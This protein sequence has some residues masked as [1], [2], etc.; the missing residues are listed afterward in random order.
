MSKW[1]DKPV[2]EGERTT[3][4]PFVAEDA[5]TI[6]ALLA[7]PELLRLTASVTSSAEAEK[8]PSEPDEG[9]INWY[10][11]RAD[12][13]ERLDLA[14]V[15]NSSGEVVGEVV[16]NEVDLTANSCNFRTLIGKAGRNRG[17]GTEATRM[18][19][20]YGFEHLGLHRISLDVFAFNPRAQRVYEKAGFRVEGIRR[21]ALRFDDEYVDEI[22]MAILAPEWTEH[23]G[24][25]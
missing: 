14:V 22:M 13:D 4:R 11:S 25:P 10:G 1:L 5:T 7:D 20:A 2:L 24:H 17:I 21:D 19:L 18:F 12:Q 15:D 6:A 8:F 23:R 16:F 3:L 9:M